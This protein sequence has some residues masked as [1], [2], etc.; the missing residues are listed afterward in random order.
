MVC[1]WVFLWGGGGPG[2]G[3][4]G[5]VLYSNSSKSLHKPVHSEDVP[6][7]MGPLRS[8]ALAV[9]HTMVWRPACR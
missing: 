6:F 7:H 1:G 8:V 9:V 2:G 5:G 4:G 3:G